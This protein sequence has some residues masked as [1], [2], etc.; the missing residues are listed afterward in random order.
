[1]LTR[2]GVF[3]RI[4]KDKTRGNI[5]QGAEA[6]RKDSDHDHPSRVDVGDEAKNILGALARGGPGI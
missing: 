3:A 6:Q 1:L 5:E 4:S 2:D